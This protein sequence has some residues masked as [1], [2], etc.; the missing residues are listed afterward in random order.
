VHDAARVEFVEEALC[1]FIGASV[2]ADPVADHEDTFVATHFLAQ[3]EIQ[4]LVVGHRRLVSRPHGPEGA[5]SRALASS[6]T[7]ATFSSAGSP[8]E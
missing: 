1:H 3:S 7:R 4:G 2:A 6:M 5:E 8:M